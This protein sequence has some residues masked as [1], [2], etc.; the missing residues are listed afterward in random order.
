MLDPAGDAVTA[1][2]S[3]VADFTAAAGC[4]TDRTARLAI[5]VEELIANIVEHGRMPATDRIAVSLA[6]AET[7]IRIEVDDSG[8]FHDPRTIDENEDLP[9]DRGGGAGLR[10]VRAWSTILAYDRVDGRNR[11]FLEIRD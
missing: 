10:L 9:P 4:D 1:A 2:L 8:Q 6:L 11:L 3:L 7:A 5:V